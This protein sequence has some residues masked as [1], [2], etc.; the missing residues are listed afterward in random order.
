[1]QLPTS[2]PSRQPHQTS[3][4]DRFDRCAHALTLSTGDVTASQRRENTGAGYGV[5]QIVL[6]LLTFCVLN[7]LPSNKLMAQNPRTAPLMTQ[8]AKDLN[9]D[10]PLPDYPRPQMVRKEWRNLNGRWQLQ[11]GLPGDELPTGKELRGKV[12]VPFPI[13]SA[14][15]GV[16]LHFDRLW[17]R[18]LFDVPAAWSDKHVLLHF[19]AVDYEAEVFV[20]GKR[21]GVHRGGYDA[22]S[23]DVTEYL[24][25][26]GPQE[27][28]VRVY[29][30]T[31]MGGQPRG[32]Q[33]TNPEY[34]MYTPATGI[35][36]TVWM[37][38]VESAAIDHLKMVP[39]VDN[40]VLRLTV[41][42][43]TASSHA[44]VHIAVKNKGAVV[45]QMD[46][47]INQ[48]LVLAIPHAELWSPDHPFLYDLEVSLS[49]N[50]KTLD[51]VTSYFGMRKISLAM[52]NGYTRILLNNQ[53]LFQ[54]GVL[55]Q[56]YWPDGIY[57]APTDAALKSD[58]EAA[59]A[60]GFNMVRKHEKVEP[61]RWYYWTDKLGLI[62]W[63][64]MPS[65]DPYLF[66]ES[67]TP[68]PPIDK[69]EFEMELKRMV[70]SHWNSPSI[71]LWTIFNEGQGQFDTA[72]LTAMV[73]ALDPSRLVNEASGN[74]ITG[75]GDINDLHQYPEP[76]VRFPTPHQALVCGEYGGIGFLVHRH[77]WEERGGGYTN[78]STPDDLLY[79]YA[80]YNN[81]VKRLHEGKGLSAV[82]YT[83]LTDVMTEVNGL[84]TYD[85]IPKADLAKL[86]QA[87]RAALLMP[88]YRTLVPTSENVRLTW[89]YTTVKP[90]DG[91]NAPGFD[92]N[93]WMS[94]QGLF[95]SRSGTEGTLWDAREIW[96]V[97]SFNPGSL[98]EEQ[99][100]NIVTRD[101]HQGY[102][103]IWINGV[104]AYEQ[105]EHSQSWE[106]RSLTTAARMAI[107][108]NSEN[109]LA[110]H[111]AGNGKELSLDVGLDLRLTPA[112]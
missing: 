81:Q 51:T 86:F 91:W 36:Q 87:T 100:Q 110:V 3:K 80:E 63:Q 78:V 37:E 68:V 96:M 33:S 88:E 29:D 17:Y 108:P 66:L 62:V 13:E 93:D 34:I 61:A 75:A 85:R 69:S 82:V 107:R 24:R 9:P 21:V 70:E 90:K 47:E 6:T 112:H 103:A 105:N 58:I 1:M 45:Q 65:P 42:S 94:G 7:T 89:K 27:L 109:L 26:S 54:M 57:T 40:G 39:D 10:A 14:L 102:I 104:L 77:S 72:R 83:Q 64:D 73:K 38:P 106:H 30:P 16:M 76:G 46:G 49:Q 53:P 92:V 55:D 95:K 43:A 5:V 111:S 8:W 56:G 31:D 28:I 22:F 50:G 12:I 4:M 98:T 71:V 19:G 41:Q 32:K 23:F 48:E 15:S 18:R 67:S 59:K 35:W 101:L 79:L 52:V 74:D 99:L 25:S 84:L 11:G 60:L 20:N 44:A 2:R 97:R